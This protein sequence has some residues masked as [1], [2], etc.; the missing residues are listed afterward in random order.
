MNKADSCSGVG[1]RKRSLLT[2]T[3]MPIGYGQHS[4]FKSLKSNLTSDKPTESR[5]LTVQIIWRKVDSKPQKLEENPGKLEENLGE[6][7]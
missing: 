1:I 3:L 4:E 2:S 7:L 5:N 6:K